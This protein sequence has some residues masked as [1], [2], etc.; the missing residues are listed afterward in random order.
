MFETSKPYSVEAIYAAG[1]ADEARW[2]ARRILELTGPST[3]FRD[4]AV[5]VR[6]TEVIG[7]FTAAFEEAGIPYI[8]NSGRGFYE[9]REVN[10]LSHL[11]RV[12]ANPRDEISLAVV[13]RSPLV[14]ASDEA[15]LALRTMGENI[16][17]S[18]MRL[19][20]GDAE[21]VR[22]GG[23]TRRFA[24]FAARLRMWRIRR[25]SVSFDGLLAAAIDDCGYRPASGSRGGANIDKFLAQVRA[26]AARQSLDEFVIELAQVRADNPREQ[27]APPEDAADTVKVMTV[28]SAKGLEFPVVFVAAMHKG[29]DNSIPVIAFSPSIGLGARWRN[30]A[31][32]EDKSDRFLHAIHEERKV[33]EEAESRRLLY[34]AMTRAEDHLALSFSG[35]RLQN[36]AALAI[37]SLRLDLTVPRDEVLACTAPDG[38]R[39]SLRLL[40]ADRPPEAL[41]RPVLEEAPQDA[42]LL[43]AP[44]AGEQQDGNATVTAL[45]DFAG[46]PRRYFLRHYLGFDPR[47]RGL[48][49]GGG[50]LSASELG[51]QVHALLAGGPPA[52]ADSEAVRLAGVFRQSALGRRAARASRVEREFD[53]L[54]AVEDLV[55]RGQ[56]DLWFEEGGELVI[57][58]YK[59][60]AVS[61]P[62]AHGRADDY[63][64]QLKLY[65]M[66][67]ERLTGRAAD[68]AYL[69]F[70]RPNTVVEVDLRPSLLDSPEQVVR[71]FQAAQSELDFRLNEGGHCGR[72]PFYRDLCP[73]GPLP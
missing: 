67:I 28:H 14:G 39:W 25:E 66:A 36:W 69:H 15:L 17:A 21:R 19:G 70:L 43:D 72:C 42:A 18:L 60:D 2:V 34:V 10:D 29:I 53:F 7:A 1:E 20:E 73:A 30:P 4:V 23:L 52:D 59:T 64:L 54:L 57:V 6:N 51:T 33:R 68:R 8:V 35:P 47:P 9:T 16:G 50:E 56:V 58:D 27:D 41:P 12:I 62:E 49:A 3:R 63:A 45:A 24:R 61:G 22:R 32:R 11:L 38:K 40:A 5:L 48:A 31:K 44:A 65:A 37:D 46:C 71:D 55:I 26:A 13:L